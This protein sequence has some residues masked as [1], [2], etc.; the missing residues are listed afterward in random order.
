MS[1]L[2]VGNAPWFTSHQL[3]ASLR[4][5][6]SATHAHCLRV[7]M[8][9]ERIATAMGWSAAG[10]RRAGEV[11]RLHDIGKL[12]IPGRLLRS[13]HRLTENEFI[14]MRDHAALGG[15]MIAC[16]ESTAALAPLVRAHHERL[17]GTGYPDALEGRNIPAESRVIAVADTFDALTAGRP[18][19][20]SVSLGNALS[21]LAEGAGRQW[22]PA[23]VAVLIALVG[24]GE[25]LSGES[26]GSSTGVPALSLAR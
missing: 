12:S 23:I 13:V 10:A 20:P 21:I 3:L 2:E 25:M 5:H 26:G 16:G 17:D 1:A 7:G 9:S 6:D 19:R 4:E 11:G 18:Y 15:H 14:V 24:G 22:D 8:L